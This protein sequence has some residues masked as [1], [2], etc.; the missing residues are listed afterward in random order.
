MTQKI[1]VWD[2]TLGRPVVSTQALN[3]GGYT[4]VADEFAVATA[5]Q[6]IFN[7]A[8]NIL[9]PDHQIDVF[10]NGRLQREGGSH[11]YTIDYG[12]D[13]ITFNSGVGENAIVQVRVFTESII[14]FNYIVGGGGQSIFAAGGLTATQLVDVWINGRIMREGGSHDYIRDEANDEIEFNYTVPEYA[15]VRIR[16][17]N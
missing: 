17:H 3:A 15:N 10:V 1:M 12:I 13:R 5:G 6:T 2:D 16:L 14:E 4:L 7:L 11:D 9:T 8:T